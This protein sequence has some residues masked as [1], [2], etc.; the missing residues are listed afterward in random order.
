MACQ[1]VGF[2]EMA[3]TRLEAFSDGVIAIA[4]TL[5]VLEIKVPHVAEGESLWRALGELWPSYAAYV[6]S[7]A[8]IGIMWVNH[9]ALFH[10]VAIVDRALLYWNLLLLG[11]IGLLP[12]TT[13]LLADYVDRGATGRPA[14]V[15]YA[16]SYAVAG[17]GFYGLWQHLCRKPELLAPPATAATARAALRRTRIGPALYAVAAALAAVSPPVTLVVCAGLATYFAFPIGMRPDAQA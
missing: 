12:F 16:A 3:T 7:F 4:I 2:M 5:L 8:T 1:S 10:R 17:I 15:V 9:H 6:V 11:S 13:A 14:A